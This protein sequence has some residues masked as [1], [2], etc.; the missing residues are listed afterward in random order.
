[1]L[2]APETGGHVEIISLSGRYWATQTWYPVRFGMTAPPRRRSK[3][4][5]VLALVA[6]SA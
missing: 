6:W 5:P 3:L 4:V 2:H 1:M